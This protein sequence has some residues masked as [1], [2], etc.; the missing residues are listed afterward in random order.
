MSLYLQKDLL[1]SLHFCLIGIGLCVEKASEPMKLNNDDE[2]FSSLGV[3][4]KEM[5][6]LA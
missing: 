2:S 1:D 3:I 5:L 4:L 6:T